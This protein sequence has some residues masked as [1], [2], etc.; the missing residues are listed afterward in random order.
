MK[1]YLV[2]ANVSNQPYS[3]EYRLFGI[4]DT[5]K[6]AVDYIINNPI[7]TIRE[8]YDD[9]DN[10]Q[11]YEAVTFNFFDEFNPKIHTKEKYVYRFITAFDG[12]PT[13]IG[14]YSE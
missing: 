2:I 1:K 8:A 14:G 13:Y 3:V 6:E 10:D 11:Y 7:V 12:S 9:Y 4:F 5:L